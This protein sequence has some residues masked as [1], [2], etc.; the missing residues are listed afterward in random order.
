MLNCKQKKKHL[1]DCPNHSKY[2]LTSTKYAT[3]SKICE[4]AHAFN[5]MAKKRNGEEFMLSPFAPPMLPLMLNDGDFIQKPTISK[6]PCGKN[7]LISD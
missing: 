5:K 3:E 1:E 4:L 2:L 7:Q 6:I